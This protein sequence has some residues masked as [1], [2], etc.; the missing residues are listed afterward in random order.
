MELQIVRREIV[1]ENDEISS[2]V[3]FIRRRTFLCWRFDLQIHSVKQVPLVK[4]RTYK[5]KSSLGIIFWIILQ[6][7]SN[8][9]SIKKKNNGLFQSLLFKIRVP[10]PNSAK[11]ELLRLIAADFMDKIDC[12]VVYSEYFL[13][14]NRLQ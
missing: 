6:V 9:T 2:K 5:A 11:I 1:Q 4:I 14:V 7:L 8:C 12:P 10:I 3:D 13:V